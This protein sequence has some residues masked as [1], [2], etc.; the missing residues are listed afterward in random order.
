[1]VLHNLRHMTRLAKRLHK[2]VVCRKHQ[3]LQLLIVF[4]VRNLEFQCATLINMYVPTV[5]LHS[6][7]IS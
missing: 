6:I 2:S 5:I 3:I 4:E 1:M 7:V